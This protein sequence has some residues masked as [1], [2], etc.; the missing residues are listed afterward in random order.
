VVDVAAAEATYGE[1]GFVVELD[2]FTGPID[3]LLHLIR[4]QD[5]DIFDIPISQITTQF[6]LAIEGVEALGLDR[7]GEFLEMAAVLVRIKAQMLMPRRI[8]DLGA[9]E[10]PRAEL[11]RRLLEYEHFTDVAQR[12]ESA[13]LERIRKYRRGYIPAREKPAPIVEVR[14]DWDDF[15][16]AALNV[17][18]RRVE[19]AEHHVRSRAVPMEEK[20]GL[21]L[22][23]LARLERIEF[24][25]LVEPFGDRL[26]LVV[27][28]LAGLEL[29]KRREVLLRQSAPFAALWLYRRLGEQTEAKAQAEAEAEPEAGTDV[30]GEAGTAG[31]GAGPGAGQDGGSD[32]GHTSGEAER[33]E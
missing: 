12:L 21:I 11:V 1:G 19:P 22:Q 32:S 25:R 4:E 33:H 9:L 28:M 17:G 18:E 14:L 6:L 13:Q 26:H 15:L 31:A 16:A 3:L 29:S 30:E 24:R 8:D 7:A 20:I 23:T 2:R 10:D 27:T 5:I